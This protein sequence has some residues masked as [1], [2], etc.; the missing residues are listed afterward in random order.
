VRRFVVWENFTTNEGDP[1]NYRYE[2][3]QNKLDKPFPPEPYRQIFIA[4]LY[5]IRNGSRRVTEGGVCI[6]QEGN[7]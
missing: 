5:G 2:K 7:D 1:S 3:A 4:H 6:P